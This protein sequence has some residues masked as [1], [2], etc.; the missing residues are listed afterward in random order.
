VVTGQF[1]IKGSNSV[2][3]APFQLPDEIWDINST[4]TFD[5]PVAGAFPAGSPYNTNT[6][7]GGHA[8][9]K[10]APT[11][12]GKLKK[13]LI[14]VDGIDFNPTVYTYAG[15]VIR[16][17]ST[18]W[19]ILTLGNDASETNPLANEP[20][21]FKDYPAAI[22]TFLNNGY[23]VIFL[24]FASGADYIQKNGLVLVKLIEMVN[25][26]RAMDDP[27]NAA[28]CENVI[29]GASMGG[30]VA[31]WALNYMEGEG[32][33][34]KTHTYVSFDSPQRGA[35]IPLSIQA[36]AYMNAHL[37]SPGQWNQL[38][39]PAARQMVIESLES[40]IS[41]GR[42]ELKIIKRTVNGP[43]EVL[44]EV[45][46]TSSLVYSGSQQLRTGFQTEMQSNGYPKR[47]RNVAISCGTYTG[48]S[49]PFMAKEKFFLARLHTDLTGLGNL[50]CN[51]EGDVFYLSM[52]GLPGR[53]DGI[54]NVLTFEQS[55]GSG[56]GEHAVPNQANTLFLA[57][58]PTDF[59]NWLFG[60]Q[61]PP[62]EH[63]IFR[64]KA[65]H[66]YPSF[67][68]APGCR[69]GDL[70]DLQYEFS[71]RGINT[72]INYR[73]TSF[74]P[75][76]SLLDINWPM[77]D[78]NLTQEIE[79]PEIV[80]MGL[81]PFKAV[82]APITNLRHI[83]LTSGMVQFV[84]DQAA[85][86][87][88]EVNIAD[89]VLLSG[90]RYNYGNQKILVPNVVINKDARLSVNVTG[91]INYMTPN[92]PPATSNHF[93]VF[94][95]G[96][97]VDNK[98][99]IV[100]KDGTLQIGDP[101][102]TDKTGVLHV[103]PEGTVHVKSGGILRLSNASILRIYPGAKLILDPG[104]IVILNHPEAH[105]QVAG[106]LVWNGD[107]NFSGKGY[108]AFE[109][110]H[111]LT[112][113]PD[114]TRFYLKGTFNNRYIQLRGTTLSIPS[115]IDLELENGAVEFG[116]YANIEVGQG[117][118]VTGKSLLLYGQGRRGF[119]GNVAGNVDLFYCRFD[120][121]AEPLHFTGGLG[122]PFGASANT[123][124]VKGCSFR[125]FTN[126]SL[127][128]ERHGVLFEDS[129]FF[130]DAL[131]TGQYGVYSNNNFTFQLRNC[132]MNNFGGDNGGNTT[133]IELMEDPKAL[134]AVRIRGGFLGWI[135]RSTFSDCNIGIGNRDISSDGI[136]PHL[137]SNVIITN[138]TLQ[139]CGAGVSMQGNSTTGL[140]VSSCSQYILNS[141]GISGKD[142][143][144]MINPMQINPNSLF[145][146]A[147]NVFVRGTIGAGSGSNMY[148]D[149]CY[150][151]SAPGGISIANNFWGTPDYA[152][153][154]GSW[155]VAN[156]PQL[157]INLTNGQTCAGLQG[158]NILPTVGKPDIRCGDDGDPCANCLANCPVD[159]P[160]LLGTETVRER[161]M[162][163]YG[164]V[165][166]EDFTGAVDDFMP[167]SDMY[168]PEQPTGQ[169]DNCRA[170]IVAARSL[171][172]G[173]QQSGGQ[174]AERNQRMYSDD[175][176]NAALILMPNPASGEVLVSL[177]E[178]GW[179]IR[180][181]DMYGRIAVESNRSLVQ[182]TYSVATW[183]VGLY[184]VEAV[185]PL[186]G[187]RL[188]KR[189]VVVR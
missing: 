113:G 169:S 75:T 8:Y 70:L 25:E 160:T 117:S 168:D 138:S 170:F 82:Y 101:N 110:L 63:K 4:A 161:F 187:R 105:I 73:Y 6:L 12:S 13:P 16:H 126:G 78:A 159:L 177:P 133:A 93:E 7:S 175:A 10:F 35:H 154:P 37:G 52:L 152:G 131:Y 66:A 179:Q 68:N 167:V 17:G 134:E 28:T 184:T 122:S 67:D 178:A 36:A 103:M 115:G 9:I 76:L 98:T 124:K 150:Q 30:Q 155:I 50:G 146:P 156:N 109:E 29:V 182:Q 2:N 153:Q 42:C 46:E 45:E 24:D 111:T 38:N 26:R 58:V 95:G 44:T 166:S 41:S 92:D 59:D 176:A 97:C 5:P 81:T 51:K 119:S 80:E 125:N 189:L 136:E 11:H 83:E 22:Q 33:S 27:D 129:E 89:I 140:V 84:L 172:E 86:G 114:A 135:D 72:P 47:T 120:G 158:Y 123:I 15:Q 142:V 91:T 174:E 40:A 43:T 3:S 116:G 106:E 77:D 164:K 88:E 74:M 62:T 147:P 162:D 20:S 55:P 32:M 171:V 151:Q 18:G 49:L 31:K 148:L 149:I 137:P 157:G 143:R 100:K 61:S 183:P 186:T 118:K 79:I 104:A 181:Q 185:E 23:D 71:K 34:H 87:R 128:K 173:S 64:L 102:I 69:K 121:I 60:S 39:T 180:I 127:I 130:G 94:T 54:F 48:E 57:A 19:D 165:M 112:F 132:Q 96:A 107:I 145:E 21:E 90:E 65:N 144:L 163:G 85:L 99:I 108:F 188:V 53:V 1:T 56:C 139:N 141:Y 14:F